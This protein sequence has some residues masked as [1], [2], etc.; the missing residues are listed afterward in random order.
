MI[1][2]C[3]EEMFHSTEKTLKKVF[4]MILYEHKQYFLLLFLNM[5]CFYHDE[6]YVVPLVFICEKYKRAIP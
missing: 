1:L 2:P 4:P 5:L 3:R 6:K